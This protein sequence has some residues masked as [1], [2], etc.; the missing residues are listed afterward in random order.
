METFTIPDDLKERMR[1][2]I[3]EARKDRVK[4]FDWIKNEIEIAINLINKYDKVYVLGGLGSRLIKSTPTF[5]NQFLADYKGID[6]NDVQDELLQSDDEIEVL[7]EYAMSVATATSNVNKNTLPTKENIEEIYQQLSKVKSNINFWE[8][9]ADIPID[10]NEFDH[11][12]RTNIMQEA[13]NVRGDGYHTHIREVFEEV[14]GPHNGFLQQYDGFDAND[15]L[16]SIIK[17]N[18]LVYS[19]VGNPFG[20]IQAHQRFIEW[21][22]ET[23]NETVVK[24]M[25]ETKKN[26]IQ[27]F[28]EANP[29]LYNESAPDKVVAYHLDRVESYGKV[30]WVI[31]KTD[32]EK[33]I[34]ERLS[35]PYGGNQIFFQ[36]PKFKAFPL[37]DTL[38]KLKPLIKDDGKYYHFSSTLAFRNIFKIVE[39]LFREADMI[40]YEQ[41]FKGNSNSNSRDNYIEKKT[42]QLFMKLLP[43]TTF[44]HSLGYT[45]VENREKKKTELDILGVSADTVYIIEV[46]AGE[47]NLKHK[48]GA[49]KGLKDR[50]E[51]TINEGSYQCHRALTYINENEK[52][53]F[54]YV[55]ATKRNVLTID[56]SSI[57]NYFKISV[58]F[59]HFASISAN[60][61]YLINSGV[62]SPAFKWTWIVSLYDLMIFTDLIEN[63]NDFK[64]Y[65]TYRISLYDRNDIEFTDEIDILGF[66]L[67][68]HFPVKAGKENDIL[69]IVNFKDDIETYYTKSGVG[70]PGVTKPKKKT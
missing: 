4:Y 26:F 37:N 57:K 64:E 35:I 9:S 34:F 36:P 66:F 17:L 21:S 30:F 60:L 48:R 25:R 18:S 46:K 33:L 23:P 8:L 45:V 65:L 47:L 44:Y 39:Q 69:H 61:K 41:S 2:A 28:T 51:E 11:W 68:G 13:I 63:E 10:G 49:M 42:K 1:Y 16:N 55:D 19:K 70:M 3:N 14:F 5:Y 54:E 38:L 29:D 32:K 50:L 40:Y 67:K 7:L 58:T 43:T 52:P 24:V 20:S 22:D 53:T 59:E 27:Q 31:P 6:N 15:V 62:L 12:L 56:K